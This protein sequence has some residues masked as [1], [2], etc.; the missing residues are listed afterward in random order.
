MK[1]FGGFCTFGFLAMPTK[2]F[3]C[4]DEINQCSIEVSMDMDKWVHGA[5]YNHD[6]RETHANSTCTNIL[7][8]CLAAEVKLLRPL[9]RF[10][11]TKI[12]GTLSFN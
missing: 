4:V 2:S 7:N 1:K 10:F 11:L 8:L 9:K 3:L 5:T 6:R 12:A